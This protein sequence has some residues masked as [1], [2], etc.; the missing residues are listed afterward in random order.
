VSAAAVTTPAGSVPGAT[1][2]G[3]GSAG[4]GSAGTG[5]AAASAPRALAAAVDP[6]ASAIAHP[7]D[8]PDAEPEPE[9]DPWIGRLIDGRYRVLTRIGQGGMGLVYKVEHQRMGKIAAMKVLHRDLATD[10]EVVKR[11]RREAE[12]VSKLTHPNTVQTFDFGTADGALYLVMEYV[13]GEDLGTILR[14]DGPLPFIRAAALFEQVLGALAEA[15]ELG[16]VHRDLKPENLLVTRTKDGSDHVKVLDFGLAKLSEREEIA[17]VTGRG[18]IVGTPYYMSP[19]QIRGEDLDHRSDIYSLGAMM[20]RVLTGEPPFQAQSPVGVLTKHLTDEVVPPR[21]RRPDLDI[22]AQVEAIVLRALAKKREARYATVDSMREDVARAREELFAAAIA[23]GQRPSRAGLG[24]P[25][26]SQSGAASAEPL[27]AGTGA[28]ALAAVGPNTTPVRLGA[29]ERRATA[30][31]GSTAQPRLKRE[32]VEA[33]E[34]SLRRRSLVRLVLV[35][36]LLLGAAVGGLF[37]WRWNQ[38]RPRDQEHEPNDT[39]DQATRVA[40]GTRVRG[41]LGRRL[42]D[43]EGDRDYYRA[44][45]GAS[46]AEPLRLDVQV[47]AIRN[48]DLE[49]YVLDRAGRRLAAVDNAGIGRGER[50]TSL[51]VGEETIFVGVV[52]SKLAA[53]GTPTENVTDWYELEITTAPFSP[54]DEHEPNDSDSE[55]TPIRPGGE[56]RGSLAR[57][58]DVDRYRFDGPAGR[59]KVAVQGQ[60]LP[61]LRLSA[62]GRET[63][64]G[65]GMSVELRPGSIIALERTDPDAPPERRKPLADAASVYVLSVAAAPAPP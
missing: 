49:L 63:V 18:A 28:G 58:R 65:Q 12:A 57:F 13:R 3:T 56:R 21:L 27:A 37:A 45:T 25:R 40:A 53:A 14:R 4:T 46:A 1:G 42:S 48:L 22:D 23:A 32:D 54:S 41:Q 35:P 39:I 24:A 19:E 15:H 43:T 33:F 6:R 36:L 50:L 61:P 26:P 60:G 64:A 5:S 29:P 51:E 55:A 17:D 7:E 34:R 30:D 8:D 44:P 2:S 52:E 16:I 59:Y 38:A 62:G 11:F 10:K 9:I 31:D 47:S 20:Y